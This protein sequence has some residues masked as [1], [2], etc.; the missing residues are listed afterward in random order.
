MTDDRVVKTFL[1]KLVAFLRLVIL[2]KLEN[3]QLSQ[4]VEAISGIV[5][6]AFR[7]RAGGLFFVVA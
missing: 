2:A 6:S 4:R 1:I 5:G 7:L 3:L